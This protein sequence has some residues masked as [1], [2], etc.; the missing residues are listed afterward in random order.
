[1]W[2]KTNL[3][4][5]CLSK[6]LEDFVVAWLLQ[7]VKGKFDP[8]QFKCLKGNSATFCLLDMIHTWLS[9]LESPSRHLHLCFLDFSKALDHIGYNILIDRLLELGVRRCLIPQIIDFLTNRRQLVKLRKT[10]C[11]WIP[12]TADVPPGNKAWSRIVLNNDQQFEDLIEES[13]MEVCRRRILIWGANKNQY[14]LHPIHS[15]HYCLLELRLLNETKCKEVQ[16]DAGMLLKGYSKALTAEIDDQPLE[17]VTSHN[18]LGLTIHSNLKWNFHIHD[19]VKKASKRLQIQRVLRKADVDTKDLVTIY[20]SIIRSVLEYCCAF[21]YHALPGY[22]SDELER[23]VHWKS[24]LRPSVTQKHYPST[25]WLESRRNNL[26]TKTINKILK[27]GPL[28]K[29]LPKRRVNTHKYKTRKANNFTTFNCRKERFRNSIF[30]KTIISNNS[31]T[32]I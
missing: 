21:C 1:M 17:L 30:P 27:G 19:T 4:D 31:W 2:Y 12:T 3:I 22:F 20:I 11:D 10:F 7:D 28:F 26:C 29:H 8:N 25:T 6:V 24:L 32:Y 18:V 5:S 23:N 15:R 13:S 9:Y 14:L 16:G